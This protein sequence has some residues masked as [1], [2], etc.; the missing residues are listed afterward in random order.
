[1]TVV[2]GIITAVGVGQPSVSFNDADG[3]MEAA[4]AP[5]PVANPDVA[6]NATPVDNGTVTLTKGVGDALTTPVPT[7][8][9]EFSETTAMETEAAV[10]R[11]TGAE[12]VPPTGA[13]ELRGMA[14][15]LCEGTTPVERGT[16]AKPDAVPSGTLELAG[17]GKIPWE[18]TTPVERG[19]DGGPEAVPSGA[20][21]LKVAGIMLDEAVPVGRN[22]VELAEPRRGLSV[23]EKSPT[24]VGTETGAVPLRAV[25]SAGE[26]TLADCTGTALDPVAKRVKFA[27]TTGAAEDPNGL[28]ADCTGMIEDPVAPDG[29]VLFSAIPVLRGMETAVTRAVPE[30]EAFAVGTG[31]VPDKVTLP[32]MSGCALGM[33]EVRDLERPSRLSSEFEKSGPVLPLAVGNATLEFPESGGRVTKGC[34]VPLLAIV[35]R[36]AGTGGISPEGF[37]ALPLAVGKIA[38]EFTESIEKEADGCPTLPL[39]VG[40]TTVKLEESAGMTTEGCS[41]LPLAVGRI[42]VRLTE[43]AGMTNEGCSPLP[44]AVG[45][46]A[47]EFA[48]VADRA[49]NG[50]GTLGASVDLTP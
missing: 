22:A 41:T 16:D 29:C 4:V 32:V 23:F 1:M 9:V 7:K 15:M 14:T 3:V 25:T 37:S 49:T 33:L 47:L 28:F 35:V 31:A 12:A 39:A 10:K 34:S 50:W 6:L 19:M 18:G 24:V 44:L 20:L 36:L 45:K 30:N 40:K 2:W 38:L 5:V 26:V 13:L 42:T 21:E 46:A 43:S 48:G 17:M 11:G 27:E 8:A